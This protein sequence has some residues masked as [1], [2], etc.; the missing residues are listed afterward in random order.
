MAY[1]PQR[2]VWN[3][4]EEAG[5]KDEDDGYEYMSFPRLKRRHKVNDLGPLA[6]RPWEVEGRV[7]TDSGEG[8]EGKNKGKGVETERKRVAWVVWIVR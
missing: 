8:R 6:P 7:D 1:P 2:H 4:V 5:D 3:D